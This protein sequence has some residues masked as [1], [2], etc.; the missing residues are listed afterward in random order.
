MVSSLQPEP[1]NIREFN[2]IAALVFAQLY[3]AFPDVVNIDQK[4]IAM[5]IGAPEQSW[6]AHRMGAGRSAPAVISLAVGWLASE[7]YIRAFGG[8]PGER[9]TLTTRGLAAMKAIP[10]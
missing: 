3:Q 7:G 10:A 2:Q 5:A 9:V 4:A 8:S 1:A 6:D